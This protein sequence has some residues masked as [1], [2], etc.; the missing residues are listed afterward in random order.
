MAI[1]S[2]QLLNE[3]LEMLKR[4]KG[5][6]CISIIVPLHFP[7]EGKADMLHIG[8]VIKAASD[9]VISSYPEEA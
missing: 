9:Q 2:G 5:S 3:D 4:E 6:P 8:K 1:L 7:E